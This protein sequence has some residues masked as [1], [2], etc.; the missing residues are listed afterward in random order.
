MGKKRLRVAIAAL[1]AV[2][3]GITFGGSALAATPTGAGRTADHY[4]AYTQYQYPLHCHANHTG[5]PAGGTISATISGKEVRQIG[6]FF[7]LSTLATYAQVYAYVGGEWQAYGAPMEVDGWANSSHQHGDVQVAAWH[8]TGLGTHARIKMKVQ[9]SGTFKLDFAT[10]LYNSYG[11]DLIPD[12]NNG[13]MY[14][15]SLGIP[16]SNVCIF[17]G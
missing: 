1:G 9:D 15:S 10:A 14:T 4:R 17:R 2:A 13:Y 8:W 3:L 16:G 12:H 7:Q 11:Y 5:G 6:G